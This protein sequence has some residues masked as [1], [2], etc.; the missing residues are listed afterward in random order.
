MAIKTVFR[1]GRLSVVEVIERYGSDFY[2]YGVTASPRVVPSL[3]MAMAII[4][5]ATR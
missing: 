5:K 2:V 1:E 4:A 3:S